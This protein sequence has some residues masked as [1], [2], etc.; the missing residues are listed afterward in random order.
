MNPILQKLESSIELVNRYNHL[1]SLDFIPYFFISHECGRAYPLVRA[2]DRS[3]LVH[4][5]PSMEL[6]REGSL[7]LIC[8]PTTCFEVE[9]NISKLCTC[10]F[11]INVSFLMVA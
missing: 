3:H 7:E 10:S 5:I 1:S 8:H 2:K 9:E 4:V 11:G 6:V